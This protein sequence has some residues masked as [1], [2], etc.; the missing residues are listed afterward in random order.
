MLTCTSV[1]IRN[2]LRFTH[3]VSPF[4]RG[5]S[6]PNLA[7]KPK[8]LPSSAHGSLDKLCVALRDYLGAVKNKQ[9]PLIKEIHRQYNVVIE[10]ESEVGT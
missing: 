8:K 5:Y 3:L 4:R 6:H 1:R 2:A 7:K 10:G 9:V